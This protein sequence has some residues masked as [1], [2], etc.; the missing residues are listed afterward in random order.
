MKQK[1]VKSKGKLICFPTMSKD[2]LIPKS[3]LHEVKML[4][5]VVIAG[6]AF[7]GLASPFD[8]CRREPLSCVFD[9]FCNTLVNLTDV[10]W[11]SEGHKTGHTESPRCWKN[12][13]HQMAN[14]KKTCNLRKCRWPFSIIQVGEK[15]GS[16]QLNWT[17]LNPL[18]TVFSSSHYLCFAFLRNDVQGVRLKGGSIMR[19][20]I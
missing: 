17:S 11:G 7:I 4:A 19:I 12:P 20:W 9:Y 18:Y 16:G 3:E 14:W 2:H 5:L 15:I 10:F 8:I 1:N 6:F 13:K